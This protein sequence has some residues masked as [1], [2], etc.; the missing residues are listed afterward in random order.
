MYTLARSSVGRCLQ[1]QRARCPT[2]EPRPT[3]TE[4]RSGSL[5]LGCKK[6]YELSRAFDA[7]SKRGTKNS[8]PETRLYFLAVLFRMASRDPL[9]ERPLK[10]LNAIAIYCALLL[11]CRNE[12]KGAKDASTIIT[13]FLFRLP[14]QSTLTV[15]SPK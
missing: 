4:V 13:G 8:Q 10:R 6:A 3:R 7:Q 15:C 5:G 2:W 9:H 14:L 1:F 11:I 12:K